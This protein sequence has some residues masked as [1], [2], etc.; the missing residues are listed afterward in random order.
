LNADEPAENFSINKRTI[1]SD[2]NS[3]EQA[4]A[5]S[6]MFTENEGNAL[7]TLEKLILNNKD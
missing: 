7:L 6:A 3:L 1:Y 4:V 2:I 5:P